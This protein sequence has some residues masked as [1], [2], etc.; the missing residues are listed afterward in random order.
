MK[1]RYVVDAFVAYLRDHGH[2]DLRVERRPDDENRET[3]DIDAVA[4]GFAIEHTSID[5]LPDQRRNEARLERVF[6]TIEQEF[7]DALPYHLSIGVPNAA[8]G[9]GRDR[10]TM[11]TALKRW[12]I[13]ESS[14]LPDGRTELHEGVPF[15]LI[16]FKSTS[17]RFTGVKLHS[18]ASEDETLPER[19]SAQ[20]NRKLKKLARYQHSPGIH[21]TV[22]LV[23]SRDIALMNEWRLLDA[24]KAAFQDG[25]PPGVD[26]VWYVDT[27]IP[28]S[29]EFR[30]FTGRLRAH[31]AEGR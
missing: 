12:V 2:P 3:P 28:T 27:S 24:M 14:H 20:L 15:R 26:Q 17:G 30:N 19:L 1:D 29:L 13:E 22:L 23:E 5:T 18:C 21:A 31:D 8:I 4:G 10:D 25:L 7:D 16:V 9:R 6:G 11:R